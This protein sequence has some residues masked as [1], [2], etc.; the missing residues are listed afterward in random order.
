MAG[1]AEAFQT[2]DSSFDTACADAGSTTCK[3]FVQAKKAEFVNEQIMRKDHAMENSLAVTS[4]V[5]DADRNSAYAMIRNQDMSRQVNAL[6]QLNQGDAARYT[7]DIDLTRRQFEINEYHYHNKLDTLF[8]L[9]L[10]FITV[11]VMSILI[12][13]NR[14]GALSTKVTGILTAVL[15]ILLVIVGISRYFY[16][17][18]TRDRRL[19][20]RRYFQ[21]EKEPGPDLLTTCPGPSTTTEVNLNALFSPEDIS[22][23][24]ETNSNFKAWAE[25]AE[26]EAAAQ[27]IESTIPT[28]MFG[29]VGADIGKSCKRR[30]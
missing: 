22:C 30:R 19:W 13:F 11:I 2:S 12:Y 7:H 15:A 1:Y 14:T 17:E 24:K 21:K 10:L 6:M 3:E 20:H 9:Q 4:R 27:Q 5:Y 23:A 18:R 26:K 25:A 16:T 28:S 29:G 8:F